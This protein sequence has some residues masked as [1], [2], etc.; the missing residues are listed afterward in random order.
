MLGYISPKTNY[1]EEFLDRP[2][3]V[4]QYIKLVFFSNNPFFIV[5]HRNISQTNLPY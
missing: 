2:V 3:S 1:I 5:D 4:S